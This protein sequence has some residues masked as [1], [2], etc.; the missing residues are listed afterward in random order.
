MNS[1]T[2]QGI[3]ILCVVG[4]ASVKSFNDIRFSFVFCT[5]LNFW[6][7][8]LRV[9]SGLTFNIGFNLLYIGYHHISS[10]PGLIGVNKLYIQVLILY[11]QSRQDFIDYKVD[12]SCRKQNIQNVRFLG[13]NIKSFAVVALP[14]L[15]TKPLL[16]TLVCN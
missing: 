6:P 1:L 7:Y 12:F 13:I 14:Q 10:K 16:A 11:Y 15:L 9:Y 8:C 2:K 4:Y 3:R 5:L